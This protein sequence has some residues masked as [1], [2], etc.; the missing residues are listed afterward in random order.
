MTPDHEAADEAVAVVGLSCRVA[1]A[2]SPEAFWDLLAAGISGVTRDEHTGRRAGFIEGKDEFDAAFFGISPRE[3]AAMDPQQRLMLE[4]AWEAFED[5]RLVPDRLHGTRTGVFVGVINDDYATLV[6]RTGPDAISGLTAAGLHRGMIANRLSYL[7]GLRGPSLTVDCAQSSSLVAVHLACESLRRGESTVAVAAGVNLVLAEESTLGMERMGALSPDGHSYTFDAR[8]NGYVRGEGGATVVLKRLADALADGDRVHCVIRGGAVNNDGGGAGLTVPDREAQEDVI[9]AALRRA[10]VAAADIGYVELHGTGTPV[11]DPIEAAALGAALRP[12]GEHRAVVEGPA[13]AEGPARVEGAA[14]AETPAPVKAPVA[15]GSAKT[16]VGHLEGASGIVGLVKTALCLSRGQ[17]PPTL[18]H[19]TPN[20][21]IDLDR[22]GLRV[23]TTLTEW[24]TEPGRARYAGV[25]SFGMG[26]TNCHLILTEAPAGQRP[27]AARPGPA[28]PLGATPWVLSGRTEAAL[29]AQAARLLDHCAAHPGQRDADLGHALAVTRTGFQRRAVVLG[30]DRAELEAGLRVLAEAGESA[31]VVRGTA[32]AQDGSG[33]VFVFPGQGAQWAG[34]GRELLDV[35]P[36]FRSSIEACERALAPF[37]DW[38]ATD[39]LRGAPGAPSLDDVEVVQPV[40]FAVMVSLAAVW[41]SW[42]VEPAAVVGHSQGEIAAAYV[43]GALSL[44]DAARVVALRSQAIARRLAGRGGMASVALPAEEVARRLQ[45][46]FAGVGIAVVNGPSATV[47]CGEPATLDALAVELER[48]DVRVRRIAVDY[49]SHSAYV[50]AI[51]DDVLAALAPITPG[52]PSIPFYSTL[53]ARRI[54][55][56]P[57]DAGYWYRNLRGTVRFQET[58]EALLDDGHTAFVEASAHPILTSAVQDVAEARDLPV[59]AVGTLRRDQGGPDRLLRSLAEAYV[60]GLP[61]D[62][63]ACFPGAHPLDLPTYAFQRRR[64][65]LPELDAARPAPAA[66]PSAASAAAPREEAATLDEEP[67]MRTEL[68]PMSAAERQRRVLHLVCA[69]TAVVLGF[70]GPDAVDPAVTFKN[71]GME[72]TTALELRN[73]LQSATGLRLPNTLVY[74]RPT[75]RALADHLLAELTEPAQDERPAAVSE[76]PAEDDPIA[77]VGMGCRFPGGVESPEDLWRLVATGTDAVGAFPEN[78]G[79]DLDG[80][81]DPEPGKPGKSYVRQGGFL[82][83]AAEFD[84]AFFG[85]SPREAVAMDPQQRLL[86]ET[87]WEALERSGID[88]H[89]LRGAAAGVFVGAMAQ[90]YGP[91]LHEPEQGAE[92]YLLTGGTTSVASGRIAY[93]LGLEGPAVTVDTACS[94]SL[95]ALHMAVQS[96]RSGESSLALAGGVCVMATPGMFVEFGQQRGLAPDGRSKAFSAAADGTSWGE[97]VGMV[98]LERLSDARRHGHTVLAVLRG[99]A[100]NQDGASNGLSAPNGLAQERVIRQ[101]LQRAGLTPADVDVVEAHGTGTRLGDPIEATA[102][103][104]TYG[105]QRPDGQPLLLGSLKSNIGHTQAAAGVGGVIKMVMALREGVV[106][107]TL[108]AGEPSPHVDW[109]AGAVELVTEAVD[110]PDTG[111]PRRA[112][113]SSFGISG[114]N[115]HVILE[116]APRPEP[117][118]PEPAGTEPVRPE[119]AGTEP[120]GTEPVGTEPVGTE[121]VPTGPAH[122]GA[123]PAALVLSAR[124]EVAL[125]GQA[126]RLADRLT[127]DETLSPLDLGY[128]S[129]VT[130]AAFE[131]RAVVL[132]TGRAEL[133]AGLRALAEAGE[134]ASVVRGTATAQDGSGTVFVFPGQGAQWAGMGRELLDAAPEF[135]NSIEACEEALAPFVDWSLTDVLRGTDGA[136]S[137]DRVDVVQPVSFAVMVSL[138]A[139]WRSWGVE[140]AAVVGHSQGEIAAAYVAGALSLEDA[141]RVVAL[142][143]QAI[144]RRLAGRGG[145]ASLALPAHEAEKRIAPWAG[146]LGVAAFNSPRSTVVA[147]EPDALE[148]LVEQCTAAGERARVIPV[149]YASHS[150]YVEAIEDDVLAALAPIT[151]GTPSIPFYSTLLARRIVDEPL[152]AGYWYRNLRGTVRFQETV[153]LLARDGHRAFV[154]VSAHPVLSTGVQETVEAETGTEPL[155]TVGSLR[156]DDGGL[157]RFAASAAEAYVS[158]LPV[159]WTPLYGTATPRRVE[160]P[161]YAFQRERYWMEPARRATAPDELGVEPAGHPFLGACLDLADDG[162]VVFTGRIAPRDHRWLADHAVLGTVLL[163]GTAFVDLV[164]HAGARLD[165]ADLDELVLHAPLAL[166]EDAAVRLQVVVGSADASGR[167][168]V[169]VHS[170]PE[171]SGDV[172][173]RPWTRHADGWLAASA[174][175]PVSGPSA[176][177]A[178]PPAGAQALDLGD[179]YGQLLAQGYEYGPVFQGLR[180]AWR[181]GDEVFA[182]VALPETGR[183]DEDFGLHPAALDAALHAI[184]LLDAAPGADAGTPAGKPLLPFAWNGVRLHAH[185]ATT[186]RVRLSRTPDD[187]V[188]VMVADPAGQPVATVDALVMRPVEPERLA[189]LAR[190]Q[191]TL[192]AVRWTPV[193]LDAAPAADGLGTV[194]VL[195]LPGAVPGLGTAAAHDGLAALLTGLDVGER[196]PDLLVVPVGSDPTAHPAP[197]TGPAVTGHRIAR[198]LLDTVQ[199]VLA[200]E[201]LA[202]TRLAVVTRG[203]VAT[204]PTAGVTDLAASVAWGLIRTVQTEYPDRCLLLDTDAAT[205]GDGSAAALRAALATG[206]ARAEHQLALRAGQGLAPRLVH[207]EPAADA[208]RRPL[209]GNGTVLVTGGTGTLGRLVARHLVTEHGVRHLVLTSRQ[210]GAAPGAGEL[211]AELAALGALTE[212]AACDAADRAALAATLDA[213]DPAHPLTAVVH[214]AGLL[215]DATVEAMTPE[216][217][218]RVLRPKADAAWH[219]HELTRDR[220]LSAFVL[221][222]SVAG[223]LGLGGQANYA[224]ANAFLDSL[225]HL[226]RAQGLPAVSLAWGLWQQASG[227]TGE[228]TGTDL[229]RMAR[230]GVGPLASDDGLRL[231]DTALAGDAPLLVPVALDTTALRTRAASEG[232]A[233]PPMLRGLVRVPARR[234]EAARAA[235]DAPQGSVGL[236]DRLAGLDAE[237]RHHTVLEL[238]RQCAAAVLG[239][240]S[241]EAVEAERAFSKLGFDSL[242]SVELR[243]RLNAATGLRLPTTLLFDCPTPAAVTARVLDRL[244]PREPAPEP[245]DERHGPRPDAPVA[246]RA[247]DEPVLAA[248][249]SASDDEI[250]SFIE[251]ELGIS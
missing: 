179:R 153:G 235:A 236:A 25:S 197:D 82:Y 198:D 247:G 164:L 7:L 175:A 173:A 177:S 214:A 127:S 168:P 191:D 100:V 166:T 132:G 193:A 48:E 36:V 123:A 62:L 112:A 4:L 49:A 66:H 155:L 248:I 85:I 129:A 110:W 158:G 71:L 239:H 16:N 207:A 230:S 154:E 51:E 130:R 186:L 221:F 3:A 192:F 162:P 116:Q 117:V 133:E 50:E 182:E 251:S 39:V 243:N 234:T 31:S 114:T 44:E 63:A 104:A 103:L 37:V 140:P 180:A 92:G 240:G 45:G 60:H 23:Q 206:F 102:V 35:S 187:A 200:D 211:V 52:T 96:L 171:E 19:V 137:F 24:T 118:R 78:R 88:P 205:A 111:R 139:L 142:R 185:G 69:T 26:G 138:A 242:T 143:S 189:G 199:R 244:S 172:A 61:V 136:P 220:G 97:G 213:I 80:V 106:P 76:A 40:L 84:A 246:D 167:R 89:S 150:A 93:T 225:A 169:S 67:S 119:P 75:P 77:V 30:A 232:V 17:L 21:A 229:A 54:V 22:L 218:E 161:T 65:W 38:S 165:H 228:L 202:T 241:P 20:P 2:D 196:A 160:L 29:R 212:I 33:T 208:A 141:A 46:R 47:V 42:G 115:A 209:D 109:S 59:A 227:M 157:L 250:F 125:R 57:L 144:A 99:S 203:A 181:L 90:D 219:L 5:A 70:D 176:G 34:M 128:S 148:A 15:V 126:A 149:D 1:G 249:E 226:R 87:S 147:G 108:H 14:L 10:G 74:E 64:H 184:G 105:R 13:R 53:L 120:V 245:H 237:E 152:D 201:R 32:T 131:R 224:A 55:D 217:V 170:R 58:V 238:V 113:V 68:A 86:L 12:G 95:V 233:P 9:R 231:L 98:V 190:R 124:S 135:R 27:E 121:P 83:G 210:G 79:W 73:R 134:S 94:S 11:G 6:R 122:H 56:E 188:S 81:Y 8:A 41:R 163:P 91:R 159:D 28:A 18:D 72:S 216:Q 145:M 146:R 222:S 101:A 151:P 195:G 194:A 204:E 43:A 156:R 215:D 174:P 183:S 107:R 223:T 178:W